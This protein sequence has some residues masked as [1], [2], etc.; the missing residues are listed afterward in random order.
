MTYHQEN[1]IVV[2][3]MTTS[4][5]MNICNECNQLKPPLNKNRQVKLL[6]RQVLNYLKTKYSILSNENDTYDDCVLLNYAAYTRLHEIFGYHN[7]SKITQAWGHLNFVWN[8]FVADEFNNHPYKKK[9]EPL[10]KIVKH[11]WHIRKIF[12]DYLAN[13]ST[14]KGYVTIYNDECKNYYKYLERIIDLYKYFDKLCLTNDENR[15]P[16]FYNDYKDYNPINYIHKS[17]CYTE[18]QK[19]RSV[20]ENAKLAGKEQKQL[21][22]LQIAS[23]SQGLYS[24]EEIESFM[25]TEETDFSDNST[26]QGHSSDRVKTFGNIFLGLVVTSMTSGVLYKFTPLG[27]QFRNTLGGNNNNMTSINGGEN[28]LFDYAS[29]SFNPYSGGE[30]EHYIGY[31]PA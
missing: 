13:Y 22:E 11:D 19:K 20:Y 4:I 5:R 9:C 27:R 25:T 31:H 6:C 3:K 8:S 14:I 17:K 28:E 7:N 21:E 18:I 15:C 10:T 24:A 16:D 26:L 23:H 1:F 29:A 30:D 2:L 12:Y